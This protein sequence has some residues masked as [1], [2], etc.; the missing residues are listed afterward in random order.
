MINL[1]SLRVLAIATVALAGCAFVQSTR[2]ADETGAAASIGPS[3]TGMFSK[4]P[5]KL[6]LTLR[7][8]YDDN[9]DN[10]PFSKH[11][12]WFTNGAID[13]A[14]D[15]GD[16]RTRL[17]L[18]AGFG[19]TYY[20]QHVAIQNYD[21]DIHVGLDVIYEATP[22]L[23][24]SAH[25]YGAYLTEPN[26]NFGYSVNRRVGNYFYTGDRF[27][28]TYKWAPRFA[29]AT[30]YNLGLIDYDGG[31]IGTF[32]DR[33]E[34]TIGNQFRFLLQPT[35][36]LVVEYRYQVITY[37]HIARDSTS[38]FVLGGVDHS[39]SPRFNATFRAGA[40]FRDYEAT[41][42]KTEP[43]VESAVNYAAGKRTIFSWTNHYGLEEPDLPTTPSRITYRTGLQARQQ[44]FPRITA[45]VGFYYEHDDNQAINMFPFVSPAFTEDALDTGLSVHYD[46]TRSLGVEVGYNHTQVFSDQAFREY[47]R[48]RVYG[49]LTFAF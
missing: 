10:T 49:G 37:F 35:T 22:R 28:A 25:I 42:Y 11:A 31:T 24:L 14:Y 9:V 43:Y 5:F 45:M 48:N 8:G 15:F 18:D 30:T 12:S 13:L 40:E 38:N 20:Y 41:G 26:F 3:D 47:S 44:L 17:T 39:F 6:S 4:L 23:K 1:K 27:T 36:A 46:I 29:T 32:E 19:G 7:E 33:I 34:N 2:G 16:P 21:I